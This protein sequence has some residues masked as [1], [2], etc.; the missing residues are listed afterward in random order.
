MIRLS[1]QNFPAELHMATMTAEAVEKVVRRAIQD[2]L[3]T[4]SSDWLDTTSAAA[5]C[6]CHPITL[7]KLRAQNRG[8]VWHGRGKWIRY[9]R[10]DLDTFLASGPN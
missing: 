4:V 8:P 2:A 10:T 7:V 5:Y 9:K 3:I 6:S 1:D